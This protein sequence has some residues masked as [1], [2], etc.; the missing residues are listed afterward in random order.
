MLWEKLKIV[1]ADVLAQAAGLFGLVVIFWLRKKVLAKT[2]PPDTLVASTE[3]KNPMT[4]QTVPV[5][6]EVPKE[7]KELVDALAG[8]VKDLVAKKPA[9]EIAGNALPKAIVAADG[10]SAIGAEVKSQ[11]KDELAG[12]LVQQIMDALGV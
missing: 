5:T 9:G 6:M 8:L 1:G 3:G 2:L 10:F 12:Y 7:G 11:N 4:I